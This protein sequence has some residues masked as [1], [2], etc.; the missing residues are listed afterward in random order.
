MLRIVPTGTIAEA[1]GAT[2]EEL[3]LHLVG[4]NLFVTHPPGPGK[5]DASEVLQAARRQQLRALRGASQP[6]EELSSPADVTTADHRGHQLRGGRLLGW[7]VENDTT[8]ELRN[9]AVF[10]ADGQ[11]CRLGVITTWMLIFAVS[12]PSNGE[13]SGR[14]RSRPRS[15]RSCASS[16]MPTPTSRSVPASARAT[17]RSAVHDFSTSVAG[18]ACRNYGGL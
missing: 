6:Q 2:T 5:L 13:Q 10:S 9:G 4:G 16:S 12:G 15:S 1:S 11:L 3:A 17:S 7:L 8:V 18:L 14:G